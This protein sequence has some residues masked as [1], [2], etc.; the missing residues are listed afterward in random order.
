MPPRG[1]AICCAKSGDLRCKA[2][3]ALPHAD[4]CGINVISQST[5]TGKK[6]LPREGAVL[7]WRR[8]WDL[9]PRAAL[10]AYEISSHASSTT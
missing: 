7:F 9:N 4:A 2:L 6:G 1:K 5:H 3:H 8:R 10:T